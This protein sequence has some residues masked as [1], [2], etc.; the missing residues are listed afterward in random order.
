MKMLYVRN[1]MDLAIEVM[2]AGRIILS[3]MV[4]DGTIV[5]NMEAVIG[6]MSNRDLQKI[7]K[8]FLNIQGIHGDR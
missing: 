5:L 1:A 6:H 7:R 3:P 2:N 4:V 8:V